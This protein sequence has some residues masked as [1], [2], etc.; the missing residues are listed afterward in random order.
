MAYT[1]PAR[2]CGRSVAAALGIAFLGIAAVV[3]A[4]GQAHWT[5]NDYH[6]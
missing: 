2:R 4:E 1:D 5:Y 6:L 3:L